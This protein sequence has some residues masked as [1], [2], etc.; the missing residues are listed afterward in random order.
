MAAYGA[1]PTIRKES[2]P[3]FLNSCICH[4]LLITVWGGRERERE[5]GGGVER[6]RRE[7]E[8][9]GEREI[10]REREGGVGGE[11]WMKQM[12]IVRRND[13]KMCIV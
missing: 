12:L 6:G 1:S 4:C 7:G 5:G 10:E 11:E 13:E 3:P 2:E 8:R 9:E